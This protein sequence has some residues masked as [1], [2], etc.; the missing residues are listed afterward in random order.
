MS[1]TLLLSAAALALLGSFASAQSFT[2]ERI[3]TGLSQPVFAT[4][5]PGD[6]TRLF[7]VQLDSTG[8]G[9][10]TLDF[11][12]PPMS[13]GPGEIVA[14]TTYYF[15]FWYRDPGG[16]GGSDHDFSDGLTATFCP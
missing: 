3:A 12:T 8:G 6:P 14:R 1:G 7:V 13:S 4:S 16:P 10:L 9:G 15:Q 2:T 11:T 5:A